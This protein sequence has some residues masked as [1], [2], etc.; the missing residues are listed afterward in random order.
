MSI[1]LYLRSFCSFALQMIPGRS[2]AT[3][4]R[5]ENTQHEEIEIPGC[6]I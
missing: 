2:E 5:T 3:M 6:G 1:G 4:I